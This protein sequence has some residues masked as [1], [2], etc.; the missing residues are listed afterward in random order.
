MSSRQSLATRD[1]IR[2]QDFEP[3]RRLIAS[4]FKVAANKPLGRISPKGRNDIHCRS[5]V[6][7]DHNVG[8]PVVDD[9]LY[10]GRGN[11]IQPPAIARGI[12]ISGI[13]ITRPEVFGI[14]LG[15]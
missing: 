12:G 9:C 7:C 10:P 2:A 3:L 15:L 13:S 5:R 1:L 14:L 8:R 6:G 11:I 4:T